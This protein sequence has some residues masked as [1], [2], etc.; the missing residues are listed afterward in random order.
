MRDTASRKNIEQH[1]LAG[2]L[3]NAAVG[4]LFALVLLLPKLLRL[5]RNPGTWL[6]F[7]VAL[8]ISGAA[9]VIFPLSLAN[10]WITAIG[11]LVMFAA[12]V[13]L[14]S[15]QPDTSADRKARELGA[16]VVVN[17]GAYQP[18]NA[19]AASVRLFVGAENVWALDSRFQPLLV[20]PS[21]EISFASVEETD[22]HWIL[23]IRWA[24]HSAEFSFRGIFAE[25]RAR[26]AESAL[27]GVMSRRLPVLPRRRA[28]SA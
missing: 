10:S 3:R 13:L 5:R 18:G 9:L 14:P 21:A 2:R 6:L 7:R 25:R 15:P 20:I 19:P 26:I 4:A 28:A 8:G 22:R 27:R 1:A 12:A 17:G 11:G 24:E 16:Q 23:W